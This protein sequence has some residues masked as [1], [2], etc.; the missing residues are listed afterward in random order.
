[1]ISLPRHEALEPINWL[2]GTW[3]I[4]RPGQGKFPTIKSFEYVGEM[5]FT[6]LGQ[7]LFNY[8][9]QTWNPE[10]K[11]PMQLETGFLKIIPGTNNLNFFV[12]Q[13][14]GLTTIEQGEVNNTQKKITL[15]STS[16]TR[17][18]QGSKPPEV[19]KV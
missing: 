17:P 10:T 15:T 3:K 5:S 14:F 9:S 8:S 16:V 19:L 18:T 13:N 1:M 2:E 12:A 4:K 11:K 6:S 7:P